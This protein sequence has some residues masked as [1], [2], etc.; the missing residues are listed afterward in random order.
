MAGL[1][2]RPGLESMMAI[3]ATVNPARPWPVIAGGAPVDYWELTVDVPEKGTKA[4]HNVVT[5]QVWEATLTTIRKKVG[6]LKPEYDVAGINEKTRIVEDLG[7]SSGNRQAVITLVKQAWRQNGLN[8]NPQVGVMRSVREVGHL[9]EV[10]NLSAQA[11][12]DTSNAY[13]EKRLKAIE[14]SG[15]KIKRSQ[16]PSADYN[17]DDDE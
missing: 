13:L 9:I 1:E 3:G 12:N 8:I 16:Y 5:P 7:V 2:Q 4:V 14:A 15:E 17:A 10:A 6:E 11:D